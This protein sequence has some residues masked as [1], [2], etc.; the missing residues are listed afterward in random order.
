MQLLVN[1]N[2]EFFKWQPFYDADNSLES[3]YF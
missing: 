2:R 1:W 3:G